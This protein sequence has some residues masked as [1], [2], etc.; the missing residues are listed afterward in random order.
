MAGI[1]RSTAAK[2]LARWANDALL[3]RTTTTGATGATRRAPERW[4]VPDATSATDVADQDP[5]GDTTA[6]AP[7]PALA[8][9]DDNIPTTVE[10]P[11]PS[12]PTSG[13]EAGPGSAAAVDASRDLPATGD[14]A[15]MG[16]AMRDNMGGGARVG[17]VAR[18]VA[19]TRARRL[20]PGGLRGMVEDHRREHSDQAFGPSQL[21]K[22]L[23]RS[24][25]AV[26]NA[27]LKLVEAGTAVRAQAKPL[28]YTLAPA[29]RAEPSA[30]TPSAPR[31][32]DSATPGP[33][34]SQDGR[35]PPS[36]P[37]VRGAATPARPSPLHRPDRSIR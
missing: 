15:D 31:T 23:G 8:P 34:R 13:P 16:A 37:S 2:I 26:A 5:G 12:D 19:P 14:A 21:G 32:N 7:T 30:A 36:I 11:D 22:A 24:G 29:E 4:S 1:G 20:P 6:A 28:R 17:A 10:R 18:P 33:Q 9:T 25:G 35:P 3:T 27:L